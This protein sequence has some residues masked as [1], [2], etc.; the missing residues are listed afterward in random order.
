MTGSIGLKNW[1]WPSPTPTAVAAPTPANQSINVEA[2]GGSNVA[3][4]GEGGN[5]SQTINT[6]PTATPTPVTFTPTPDDETLAVSTTDVTLEPQTS[7]SEIYEKMID[8]VRSTSDGYDYPE[9]SERFIAS[10]LSFQVGVD[11]VQ[12]SA[13][14]GERTNALVDRVW[15][16]WNDYALDHMSADPQEHGQSPFRQLVIRMIQGTQDSLSEQDEKALTSFYSRPW[17][18]EIRGVIGEIHREIYGLY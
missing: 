11:A 15:D 4:A 6:T 16:D 8:E 18:G 3:I 9:Q 13:N 14:V 7:T 2:S 1:I 5:V 10:L 17:T 12:S